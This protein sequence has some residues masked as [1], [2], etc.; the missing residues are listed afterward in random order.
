MRSTPNITLETL[1]TLDYCILLFHYILQKY[2]QIIFYLNKF[3]TGMFEIS[4]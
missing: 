1:T 3:N 2:L 4:I